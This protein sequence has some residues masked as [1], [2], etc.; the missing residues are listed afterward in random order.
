MSEKEKK[1]WKKQKKYQLPK[2]CSAL[3]IIKAFQKAA[4]FQKSFDEQWKS[5]SVIG[6]GNRLSGAFTIYSMG[7]K[8]CRWFRRK[9]W[10]FFGKKIWIKDENISFALKPLILKQDHK[11][12]EITIN[13]KHRPARYQSTFENFIFR[14]LEKLEEKR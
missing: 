1:S 13:C 12:V 11:E 3:D 4:D 5:E 9:K 14:F 6:H 2:K 7:V 10:F 8:I